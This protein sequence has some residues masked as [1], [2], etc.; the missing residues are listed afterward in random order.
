MSFIR[1]A[2]LALL[3]AVPFFGAADCGLDGNGPCDFETDPNCEDSTRA[4]VEGTITVPQASNSA[5]FQRVDGA[6]AKQ[7]KHAMSDA[8]AA[9]AEPHKLAHSLPHQST[10]NRVPAAK[11]KNTRFRSGEAVVRARDPVANRKAEFARQLQF[12]LSDVFA[13]VHVDVRLCGTEYRCL[14][15]I[16]DVNGKK[17]DQMATAEAALWL[18]RAPFL[19]YAEKNL[20][21]QMEL[22]PN[23]E[24]FTLQW[25]YAAID[26]PAAWDI[27]TGD[28]SRVA[29]I[30]DTGV[31]YDHPD[32]TDRVPSH[33]ADLIDDPSVSNDG[34]GRD[35]DGYDAGDN[36]CGD[37]CNSFHGS[38]V[39]GTIGATTD[40][41]TMVAGI[42]W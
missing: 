13:P 25:H 20:I 32:L 29:A 41:G 42:T 37:G 21:L 8:R 26:L 28:P 7:I 3:C 5:V 6:L 9:S 31:L 16:T 14:A 12:Y 4:Q 10:H 30:I 27:T 1:Y 15:D 23:D 18:A 38:H 34:D 2:P 17:L 35:M 33:G 11:T 39:S 36:E 24:F 19:Q 22:E 40:N